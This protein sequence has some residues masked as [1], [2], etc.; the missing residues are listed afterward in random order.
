[1]IYKQ[2]IRTDPRRDTKAT[3]DEQKQKLSSDS[4]Y[5]NHTPSITTPLP[6]PSNWM[7]FDENPYGNG[8]RTMRCVWLVE[9]S[10]NTIR[11]LCLCGR[12]EIV[13]FV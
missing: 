2:H 7:S 5:P 6:C 1:M 8:V 3:N 4:I 10:L 13:T 9:I 11:S 12:E